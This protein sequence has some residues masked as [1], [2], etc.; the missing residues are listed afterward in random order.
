MMSDR[1]QRSRRPRCVT[2]HG[3]RDKPRRFPNFQEEAPGRL[4]IAAYTCRQTVAATVFL[5]NNVASAATAAAAAAFA[6]FT[7][8][9]R[10]GGQFAG[11][12]FIET[13]THARRLSEW[14]TGPYAS[15]SSR[16]LPFPT[17]VVIL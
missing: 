12:P 9:T 2:H 6:S 13:A 16:S 5:Q 7:P 15:Y 17:V 10:R 3:C 1:Q 4:F 14:A 11:T 8:P